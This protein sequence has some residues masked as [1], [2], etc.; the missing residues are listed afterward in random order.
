[1]PIAAAGSG[2]VVVMARVTGSVKG[3]DAVLLLLSVTFTVKAAVTAVDNGV[4]VI[5]PPV[6]NDSP[7]G[8]L[9]VDTVH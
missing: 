8:R 6:D 3:P 7:A 9:P 4:P 2:E 1:M 5:A